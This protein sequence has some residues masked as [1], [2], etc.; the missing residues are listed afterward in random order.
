MPTLMSMEWTGVTSDQYNQA[1][2][3]LN[4]DKNPPNGGILHVAG[5]D[6]GTLRVMDIWESQQSFERFQGERLTTAVQK[7]GITSQ[8]KVLFCPIHNIYA[9]NLEVIRKTGSTAMPSAA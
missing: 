1:L 4:L 5:F 2:R 6:G 8:P 3:A 9:P 7:A